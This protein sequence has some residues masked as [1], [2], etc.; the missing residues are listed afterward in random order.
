MH[1]RNIPSIRQMCSL[2][3]IQPAAI[4]RMLADGKLAEK[5]ARAIEEYFN[6]PRLWLDIDNDDI[7]RDTSVYFFN[8]FNG[9]DTSIPDFTIKKAIPED[10]FYIKLNNKIG[11]ISQEYFLR[12]SP[13][14]NIQSVKYDDIC[15]VQV[16][17]SEIFRIT[18]FKGDCFY[19]DGVSHRISDVKVIAK[20]IAIEI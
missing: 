9:I 14:S 10:Q 19:V 4:S 8:N 12:F 3:G 7:E 18:Q 1:D 11:V 5:H 15:I 16:R 13:I 20:C 2:T 6:L 17:I